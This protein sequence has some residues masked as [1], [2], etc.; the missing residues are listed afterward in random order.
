MY[1]TWNFQFSSIDLVAISWAR[2]VYRSISIS[3]TFFL[4]LFFWIQTQATNKIPTNLFCMFYQMVWFTWNCKR[5][6]PRLCWSTATFGCISFEC[7]HITDRFYGI[8]QWKN[9]IISS[10]SMINFDSIR[11]WNL[12]RINLPISFQ[13]FAVVGVVVTWTCLFND[14]RFHKAIKIHVNM[15]LFLA[16]SWNLFYSC[17]IGALYIGVRPL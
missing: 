11:W 5:M 16:H 6:Q 9:H 8:E 2:F 17:I 14:N 4:F 15:F 3:R 1:D 10:I 7:N 12:Q 13:P